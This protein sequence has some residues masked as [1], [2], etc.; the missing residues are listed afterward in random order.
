MVATEAE[1]A[2]AK[3]G[4][5]LLSKSW[6]VSQSLTHFPLGLIEA[7]QPVNVSYKLT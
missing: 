7:P 5:F 2:G 4:S 3:D 6:S 1:G